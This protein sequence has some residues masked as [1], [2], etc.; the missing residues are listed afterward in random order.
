M[1]IAL[2]IGS[3]RM[4]SLRNDGDRLIGRSCRSQYVIL[5]N[6]ESQRTLLNHMEIPHAICDE[7]LVVMGDNATE[8]S[9]LFQTPCRQLLPDGKIPEGDPSARQITA[10]LIESLL[11]KPP[12]PGELCC[13]SFPGV[14]DA[15]HREGHLDYEFF[16]R[17]IRLQGYEPMVIS[18]GLAVSLAELVGCSFTG[19]G[20]NLGASRAE[21]S[22]T[23]L[24]NEVAHCSIPIGGNWIDEQFAVRNSE[25][26]WDARGIRYPDVSGVAVWKES[27]TDSITDANGGREK[28][29]AEICREYISRVLNETA[30]E[31]AGVSAVRNIPRPASISLCGGIVQVP[32]FV[33]IFREELRNTPF[34]I[35]VNQ[36]LPGN[37][38][39]FTVARGCLI[40]AELESQARTV[41]R[42]AA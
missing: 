1:S 12:R 22:L 8:F 40:Y 19:I 21:V 36:L 29:L 15:H 35:E 4:R 26:A 38:P 42:Q 33:D 13:L 30:K 34:P 25:Y 27:L 7:T 6:D 32:G 41:T 24:G 37:E 14:P 17:L 11:P 16:T 39:E 10:S 31:F 20:M 9:R 2:D 3:Y 28:L 23:H 18:S 5:D